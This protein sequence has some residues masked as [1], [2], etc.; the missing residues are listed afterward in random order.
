MVRWTS[1]YAASVIGGNQ[2]TGQLVVDRL[3]CECH[4]FVRICIE[5]WFL[6]DRFGGGCERWSTVLRSEWY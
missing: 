3:R 6:S 5:E 1:V 2:G 4:G